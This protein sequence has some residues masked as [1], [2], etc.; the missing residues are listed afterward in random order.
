M[1]LKFSI[2]V[3]FLIILVL[4]SF[5]IVI[6]YSTVT[7]VI[8][9]SLIED[10]LRQRLASELNYLSDQYS[11][12]TP[13]QLPNTR[14]LKGYLGA[15]SL[16]HY[17][18]AY[19]SKVSDGI[20]FY[21]VDDEYEDYFEEN[22]FE[23]IADH[24]DDDLTPILCFAVKTFPDKKQLF[25]V[26]DSNFI[27]HH[28]EKMGR[29]MIFSLILV[30]LAGTA[31]ALLMAQR[32][33]Q[34]LKKLSNVI[35]KF[36]PGS[37][38]SG[39]SKQF[40]KDEFGTIAQALE[41]AMER[42]KDFIVREQRFTRDASHELRTPVTVIKGALEL[43]RISKV[44]EEPT[45]QKLLNRVERSVTEMENTIESLLWLARENIEDKTNQQCMI[46]PIVENAIEQN[47]HLIAG[48][49][50]EMLITTHANPEMTVSAGILLIA[51]SN[52]IRNA[53]QFTAQGRIDV[54]VMED[55]IEV[56]DTGIGIDRK[57]ISKV[58]TS[59]FSHH[60]SSGFGFGLDIVTRLCE[61]MGWVLKIESQSGQGT[62]ATLMF[63]NFR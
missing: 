29:R 47:R 55:R 31:L 50:V 10:I 14:G 49:P 16:P 60:D 43:L 4:Y 22:G 52:L 7:K 6:A 62:L 28:L 38:P 51:V 54:R 42:T 44:R 46:V 5:V 11:E 26:I 48:K 33:I 40:P 39:F 15:E 36:G 56:E 53:C 17:L 20:Y 25:L 12:N 23:E 35:E 34:P 27:S 30:S 19:A 24:F 61:R 32:V 9:R 57:D 21:D 18:R 8:Q 63:G 58:A 1:K 45:V 59:G 3:R 2:R 41:Q 37:L 13:L